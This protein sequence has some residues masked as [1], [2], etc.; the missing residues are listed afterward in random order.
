MLT[1]FLSFALAQEP[2]AEAPAPPSIE[3]A[4]EAVAEGAAPEAAPEAAP[5]AEV[6]E[7]A[8]EIPESD[9]EAVGLA[10]LLLQEVQAGNWSAVGALVL[11]ILVFVV[12]KYLWTSIAKDHIPFVVIGLGVAGNLGVALYAGAD[13]VGATLSGLSVGL[14]AIGGWEVLQ[15]YLKKLLPSAEAETTIDQPGEA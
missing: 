11:M 6:E 10:V 8:V 1:I 2:A 15:K 3:A 7:P 13:P 14:A 4:V 9:E 12:R 5:W